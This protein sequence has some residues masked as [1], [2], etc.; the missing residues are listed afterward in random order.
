MNRSIKSYFK[1]IFS[2]FLF[3][4]III[5]C[6]DETIKIVNIEEQEHI[7]NA[8]KHLTID[9]LP[10]LEKVLTAISTG[11]TSKTASTTFG[12]LNLS[13]IIEYVNDDGKESYTFKIEN[14]TNIES[15]LEFENLH[16]IKLPNEEG[17]LAFILRWKPNFEWYSENNYSFQL[18]NFTGTVD[19]FDLEYNFLKET[20]FIDG[21]IQG[22]EGKRNSIFSKTVEIECDDTVECTCP[23]DPYCGCSW[24]SCPYV[25]E[26]GCSVTGGGGGGGDDTSSGDTTG[27]T[28]T[29]ITGG[30]TSGTNT[31]TGAYVPNGNGGVITTPPTMSEILGIYIDLTYEQRLW[32]GNPENEAQ[33]QE[34][35]NFIMSCQALGKMS[36]ECDN[37]IFGAL[38]LSALLEGDEPNYAL[39]IILDSTFEDYPCQKDIV[40]SVYQNQSELSNHILNVFDSSATVNLTYKVEVVTGDYGQMQYNAINNNLYDINVVLGTQT[41]TDGSDLFIANVMIHENVHAVLGAMAHQG[42]LTGVTINSGLVQ[43]AEA[44]TQWQADNSTSDEH[45]FMALLVD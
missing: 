17:Y 9:E 28:G 15:P 20:I 12:D 1:F 40:E 11:Q 14:P 36:T 30:G 34:L 22:G 23:G 25:Y 45:V 44:Y 5:S 26:T 16:L 2:F 21:I 18:Y 8:I 29:H 4:L 27:G 31:S 7:N 38:A 32:V 24:E 41:A 39:E 33:A 42:S 35:I 13:D 37:S 10:Q 6:K 19:R 3:G 43:L